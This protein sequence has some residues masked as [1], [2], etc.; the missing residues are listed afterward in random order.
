MCEQN[1]EWNVARQ[2]MSHSSLCFTVVDLGLG[3]VE[4]YV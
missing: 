1:S 4:P 3:L 2:Q